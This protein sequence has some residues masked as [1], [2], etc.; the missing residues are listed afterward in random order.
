LKAT[1]GWNAYSGI[2][3]EDTYGFAALPGGGGGFSG[4]SFGNAGYRGYWWSATENGS[5][6]AYSRRMY[7]DY[8]D[9][10]WYDDVKSFLLSVRCLQD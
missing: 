6:N 10:Y 4:G 9:A 2:V 1:S 3:N 7:Y 5:L 8:E